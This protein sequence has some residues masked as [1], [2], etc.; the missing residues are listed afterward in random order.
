MRKIAILLSLCAVVQLLI[1]QS[2]SLHPIPPVI[3]L[4]EP[5]RHKKVQEALE[6]L[7]DTQQ[8][9]ESR[10]FTVQ[11]W[12]RK[13]NFYYTV[14]GP[15]HL[16]ISQPLFAS[17]NLKQARYELMQL[18]ADTIVS[19]QPLPVRTLPQ[20][21]RNALLSSAQRGALAQLSGLEWLINEGSYLM[22]GGRI[23]AE[24]TQ[25][26]GTRRSVWV[27][28]LI[29]PIDRLRPFLIG[30]PSRMPLSKPAHSPFEQNIIYNT[31]A[32]RT[33]FVQGMQAMSRFWQ[34][35]DDNVSK[36]YESVRK[37]ILERLYSEL[38]NELGIAMSGEPVHWETL[39]VGYKQHLLQQI[40]RAGWEQPEM[41]RLSIY[42][43]MWVFVVD[44]Q[45]G[46]I[47]QVSWRL[48]ETVFPIRMGTV[49]LK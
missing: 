3:A 48:D 5:E 28:E 2:N 35:L 24:W 23:R 41:V 10:I 15:Y 37:T 40:Q 19:R 17:E 38:G 7:E 47:H 27:G 8:P 25:S 45:R 42:P 6:I 18:L 30:E 46:V 12:S 29:P 20:H 31:P 14:D 22:I 16:L 21:V 26:D 44:T 4:V 39:P 36:N 34:S 43:S 49:P 9:L 13:H 1:A 33:V 32:A 11:E